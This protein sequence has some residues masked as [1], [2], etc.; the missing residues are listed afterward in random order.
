M[1]ARSVEQHLAGEPFAF[2][3]FQA[4]RLLARLAPGRTPVGQGGPPAREVVRFR[5]LASLDF[6]AS[7]VHALLPASAERPLPELTV[8]FLGLHGPSGVLPRHYT[9]R[10][11][12]LERDRKGEE[13]RAFR[14]WLDLFN[15]R[16]ISLFYRAWEK[17]RFWLP[18]ERGEYGRADPDPF[19]R[20]LLSLVGLGTPGLRD[21]LRVVAVEAGAGRE[22][23]LAAVD[24]RYLLHFSGLLASRHRT[25]AGL[26]ALL[27]DYF[28]V[29][30]RVQQ[31]VGQWLEVEPANQT[32]LGLP[33][34]N[35]ELGVNFLAGERVWDVQSKLRVRLGPLGYARFADFLPDRS[36]QPDYKSFFL[37]V[38]LVRLYAGPELDFDVQPLL[39]ADAVPEW[40]LGDEPPGPRLGW[41]TWLV[42]QQP[43]ADAGD[44]LFGGEAVVRLDEANASR[45]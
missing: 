8:T 7:A 27:G 32:R 20:A 14:D 4:V 23:P 2:G 12:R 36:P 34:G 37:L 38:H 39:R 18:Y 15:H 17:Y 43:A 44:A 19:T 30:V 3:F 24:D 40:Q 6:P 28:Q 10:I 33:D 25:A 1:P 31:F 42:S 22:R 26:A 29:P 35:C 16:L 11:L 9:E 13:R 45:I 21:R 5:A 41:N